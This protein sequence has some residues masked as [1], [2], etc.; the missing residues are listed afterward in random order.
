MIVTSWGQKYPLSDDGKLTPMSELGME[1]QVTP[2][3]E[4]GEDETGGPAFF[5]I[6]PWG[7][8]REKIANLWWPAH[9]PE[10][11]EAVEQ[12]FS[13]LRLYRLHQPPSE[14]VGTGKQP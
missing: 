6:N 2:S 5:W 14:P 4:F 3:F 11:T 9:P 1:I 7:G 8:Q 10:A 12:L 13:E